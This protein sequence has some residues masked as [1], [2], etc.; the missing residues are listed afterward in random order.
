[1]QGFEGGRVRGVAGGLRK[2]QASR[3][4]CH[5]C[6]E[7]PRGSVSGIQEGV[8]DKLRGSSQRFSTKIGGRAFSGAAT[9]GA[10]QA[11]FH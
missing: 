4:N 5:G 3:E 8:P 1:M 6:Q 10:L 9:V 2:V 7:G 11:I